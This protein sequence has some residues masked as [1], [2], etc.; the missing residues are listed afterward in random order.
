M[1]IALENLTKR[2]ATPAGVFGALDGIDLTIGA[3]EFVAVTGKSGSGK[4][5]LLN[6]VGGIDRPPSGSVTVAGKHTHNMTENRL[7]LWRGRTLGFVF[8]F[9]Q[10]LPTLTAAENV[11]LPMDFN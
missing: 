7:A 1:M 3:G 10:L 2:Y 11:M 6:M 8:Q 4:S 9:F 5:T